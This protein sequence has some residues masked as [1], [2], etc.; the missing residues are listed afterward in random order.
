MSQMSHKTHQ[1]NETHE[2][3]DQK[4][5]GIKN[6]LV[7]WLAVEIYNLNHIFLNLYISKFSRTFDQME[8]A[9]RSGKQD[10]VEGSLENSVES[11]L[12]LSGVSRASY[13]EL[14]EDYQDFLFKKGLRV[15]DKNDPRVLR[16]RRILINPHE[17][18]VTNDSNESHGIKFSDPEAFANLMITLCT[19]QGFLMDR[20]LKG[21]QEKFVKE[22]GFRENLLKKRLSF[23]KHEANE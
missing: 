4:A 12:K 17:T 1:T 15:W 22:G 18:H 16:L 10:L 6:T 9:A 8:Q 7:Y 13:G 19:K 21:I 20:F 14:V 3:H 5:G 23:K 2:S 11:N